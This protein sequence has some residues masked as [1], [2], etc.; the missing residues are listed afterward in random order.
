MF[1]NLTDLKIFAF[2]AVKEQEDFN[3]RMLLARRWG[4]MHLQG[5]EI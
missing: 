5:A 2:L 3:Q 1:L 4:L